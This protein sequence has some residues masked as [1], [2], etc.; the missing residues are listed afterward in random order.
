MRRQI[1]ALFGLTAIL[2]AFSQVSSVSNQSIS[3]KYFFVYAVWKRT[4]AGTL[5]GSIQF[6]GNGGYTLQGK[7]QAGTST[8]TISAQAGYRVLPDGTGQI[9]N[10]MDPL[11]PPLSLRLGANAG[12]VSGSTLEQSTADQHDLL[13]AVQAPSGTRSVADLN[14][15]WAGV[16][17]AYLPG[18]STIA[19]AGRFRFQFDEQGKV[20][21]TDWTFHQSDQNNGAAQTTSSS[22]AYA[23]AADGTGTFD[24]IF[25]RKRFALSADGNILIGTDDSAGQEFI[26]AVRVTSDTTAGLTGRY[27]WEQIVA[28]APGGTDPRASAFAWAISNALQEINGAGLNRATGAGHFIDGPTGRLLDL[29]AMLG[30]FTIAATG[31]VD[32]GFG[33]LASAGLGA[34]SQGSQYLPWT[35]LTA[36]VTGTYSFNVLLPAPSFAPAPGQSVWLDPAGAVHLAGFSTSPAPFAPGTLMSIRGSGL[37]SGTTHAPSAPLQT[38][39]G[40]TQLL[41]NG[42]PAAL[43]EVAADHITFVLPFATA[44]AGRIDLQAITAAGPSNTISILAAPSL[45]G[46]F[47][48]AGNGLGIALAQHSDGTPVNANAPA[49]SNEAITLYATGLG[50][51]TGAPAE[52]V[53]ATGPA[54]TTVPVQVDFAGIFGDVL[55]AGLAPGFPGVYQINVRVP[56]N[57]AP[58]AA[59][60]VRIYQGYTQSHPKVTIPIGQ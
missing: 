49:R 34:L 25:G 33:G 48:Q 51:V 45:P 1:R 44:G 29:S 9:G 3:G 37:A 23:V 20:S 36:T 26:C 11:M 31:L 59:A 41:A 39:L 17:N 32:L 7:W 16:H 10:P 38:T 28:V 15:A 43:Y 18:S 57:V 6:D 22:G 27:Y 53:A 19:R 24:T 4:D 60:N 14:G 2:P 42:Q 46:L 5:M 52:G 50:V 40:G 12:T 56:G 55:Y 54:P 13:I 21:S 35:N 8:R 58:T 30:P 47:S